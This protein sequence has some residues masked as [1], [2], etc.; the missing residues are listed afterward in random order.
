M[1]SDSLRRSN[2]THR[3]GKMACTLISLLLPCS[4]ACASRAKIQRKS[5]GT[6]KCKTRGPSLI[7]GAHLKLVRTADLLDVASVV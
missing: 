4:E 5:V 2:S 6:L 7:S 3:T 1:Q